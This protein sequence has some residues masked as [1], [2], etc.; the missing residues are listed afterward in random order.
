[1]NALGASQQPPGGLF[2][3]PGTQQTAVIRQGV[4]NA[5]TVALQQQPVTWMSRA[6]GVCDT[7]THMCRQGTAMRG[8]EESVAHSH[9]G[10][11]LA[12]GSHMDAVNS[13]ADVRPA[14]T[15]I[16]TNKNCQ[17][18]RKRKCPREMMHRMMADPHSHN[19]FNALPIRPCHPHPQWSQSRP[20]R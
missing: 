12:V 8:K 10:G 1:M 13:H 19:N 15:T 11:V 14:L 5:A 7:A 3:C 20:L 18:R 16:K 4:S 9:S 2:F 6:T 17:I